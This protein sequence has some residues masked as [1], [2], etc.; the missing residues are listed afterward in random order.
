[1]SLF[2]WITGVSLC[3]GLSGC[4]AEFNCNDKQELCD[5][6]LLIEEIAEAEA[7]DQIAEGLDDQSFECDDGEMILESQLCDDTEDCEDGEDED[8]C[9]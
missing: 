4:N 2:K 5:L 6:D 3:L 1:M 9:E 8:D 7:E